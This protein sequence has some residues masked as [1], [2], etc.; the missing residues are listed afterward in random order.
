[1]QQ[2]LRLPVL[3]STVWG[4]DM[5]SL[6]MVFFMQIAR[7]PVLAEAPQPYRPNGDAGDLPAIY[8]FAC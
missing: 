6:L 1:M 7:V 4:V 8:E 3:K 5:W 2:K